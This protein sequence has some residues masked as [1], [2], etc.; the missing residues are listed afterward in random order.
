[1]SASRSKYITVR[2]ELKDGWHVFTSEAMPGLLVA[3]QNLETAALDVAP[4]I[5]KLM[6]LDTG[7]TVEAS[8]FGIVVKIQYE[9]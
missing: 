5:M 7:Q 6:E 2:H 8:W 1:M 9:E 4:S 3:S